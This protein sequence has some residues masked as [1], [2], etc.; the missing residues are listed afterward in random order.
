MSETPSLIRLRA[1]LQR[2]GL[3]RSSVYSLVKRGEF[4]RQIQPSGIRVALWDSSQVD[5][6]VRNQINKDYSNVSTD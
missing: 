1:V 2:T 5:A 4:P 6:W 3:S